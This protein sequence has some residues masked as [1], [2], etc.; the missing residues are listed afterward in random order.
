MVE[1]I[2]PEPEPEPVIEELVPQPAPPP[3]PIETPESKVEEKVEP[4][5]PVLLPTR[6]PKPPPKKEN[7]VEVKQQDRMNALLK[8]LA[9]SDPAPKPV[10]QAEAK[11]SIAQS[12]MSAGQ[13]SLSEKGIVKAQIEGCWYFPAGAKYAE[14]LIVTLN[15][16]MNPDRTVR[17]IDILNRSRMNYDSAFRAA[18][19][20]AE[21]ALSKPACKEL[22]LPPEKYHEWQTIKLN[23]NP[24]GML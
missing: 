17:R 5:K 21:R 1:E 24:R 13:L 11:P 18:A 23:F 20:A 22:K 14:D 9:E 2:P 15:L 3:P 4:E 7:P 19:E 16:T 6:K 12:G 8:N 10:A